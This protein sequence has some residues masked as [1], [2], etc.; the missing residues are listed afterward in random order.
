M[1]ISIK[2]TYL[3]IG[4]AL[5]LSSCSQGTELPVDIDSG[6]RQ[7]RFSTTLPTL[8]SRAGIVYDDN[9]PYFNVA[10]FDCYDHSLLFSDKTVQV[11]GNAAPYSSSDCLWPETG[12]EDHV[13][14]FFGYY[15]ALGDGDDTGIINNTT[16]DLVDYTLSGFR[17][18]EQ[19]VDQMDFITA[20]AFG[21]MA[22]HQ[23]SGV[24]LPFEHQLSRVD[25]KAYSDHKS[26]DIEIAGVRI[27]GIYMKGD[28][29][30]RRNAVDNYGFWL[31]NTFT[32]KGFVEYV[33][34]KGDI[35][36]SLP[37]GAKAT[38]KSDGALSLM[39]NIRSAGN[40]AMI[41]PANYDKP[42]AGAADRKNENKG[43]YISVLLRVTDAT[44]TAGEKPVEKQRYPY[45]DLRQGD[46][47]MDVPRVYFAID[48]D[49]D[50][51]STRL[52]KDGDVYYRDEKC[53]DAYT[54]AS[55]EEVREFG[56]A[57]VPVTCKLEPGKIYTYIL[58]YTYGVG[59]HGPEIVTKAPG[60]GDP[61][62]NDNVTVDYTVKE[63]QPGGGGQFEV[64]GS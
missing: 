1:N 7:I 3:L 32:D 64:P 52:Y 41:I 18:N 31:P 60:A 15:P 47:A 51:I 29:T 36:V 5:A 61:I 37:K 12:K 27:C 10:A 40:S 49:N 42:W 53:E 43:M 62:I 23:F 56:W 16:A 19:I 38:S 34:S 45:R 50:I 11:T 6:N 21:T 9:L 13:V 55:N 48:K 24:T 44:P 25:V 30:F 2:P 26:C 4:A 17:V 22:E 39:G 46:D 8:T 57:C 14:T 35:V 33:F 58:N 59:L 20:T 54:L 63:W 28:F